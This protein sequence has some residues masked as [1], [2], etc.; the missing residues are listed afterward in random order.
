M[1]VYTL[2]P[3]RIT[4]INNYKLL[5]TRQRGFSSIL[6]DKI[7]RPCLIYQHFFQSASV[8]CHFRKTWAPHEGPTLSTGLM[9]FLRSFSIG[10]N[11]LVIF[12]LLT[13][14]RL[15]FFGQSVTGGVGEGSSDP[16]LYLWNQ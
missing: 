5:S 10:S 4:N 6:S 15:G 7:N 3:A 9:P 13:L 8:N 14:F 11:V 1:K 2:L 12:V 16:P